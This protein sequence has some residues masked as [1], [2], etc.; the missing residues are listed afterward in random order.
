MS[1]IAIPAVFVI[2]VIIGLTG[3]SPAPSAASQES[4]PAAAT[5]AADGLCTPGTPSDWASADIRPAGVNDAVVIPAAEEASGEPEPVRQL[6]LVVVTLP[7]GHCIPYSALSNQ[8]DGAIVLMVQQGHLT[9]R[10]QPDPAVK[11]TPTVM[12]GNALGTLGSV[13]ANDTQNYFPGDWITL[14]QRVRFSYRNVGGDSA[15]VLKA[16][17]ATPIVGGCSG[18]CK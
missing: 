17:W 8:K 2:A 5:P 15:I 1:R 7:P 4:S 12:R 11:G 3:G 18:G 6:Y 10:W 9:F 16:V 14:D 13:A